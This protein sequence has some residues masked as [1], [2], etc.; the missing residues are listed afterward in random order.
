MTTENPYVLNLGAYFRDK[1]EPVEHRRTVF[2]V[3]TNDDEQPLT[4]LDKLWRSEF[5]DELFYKIRRESTFMKEKDG[6]ARWNS[7]TSASLCRHW[8]LH[9]QTRAKE[10][11]IYTYRM[12]VWS[13]KVLRKACIVSY[14][15][16]FVLV[17]ANSEAFFSTDAISCFRS[18]EPPVFW[19]AAKARDPGM[20]R[21]YCGT[22]KPAPA[23][24]S[25][26]ACRSA[27]PYG[28]II[29]QSTN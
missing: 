28:P 29:M 21:W 16:I 20:S 11:R 13:W 2:E 7:Q 10:N 19:P 23:A 18:G 24:V 27:A 1:T 9:T 12:F 14:A 17:V 4:V 8:H 25:K 3:N 22:S 26:R 15:V 6:L 5:N